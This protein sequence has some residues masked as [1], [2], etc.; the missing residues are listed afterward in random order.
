MNKIKLAILTFVKKQLD[1]R[2]AKPHRKLNQCNVCSEVAIPLYQISILNIILYF[3]IGAIVMFSWNIWLGISIALGSLILN[4]F[5]AKPECPKCKSKDIELYQQ[6]EPNSFEQKIMEVDQQ[7]EEKLDP[8][9]EAEKKM[10]E[11]IN[12]I[13]KDVEKILQENKDKQG[14]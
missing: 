8:S 14:V 9:E 11:E 3:V 7:F 5:L 10:I 2:A 1:K 13:E 4:V 12:G 6:T